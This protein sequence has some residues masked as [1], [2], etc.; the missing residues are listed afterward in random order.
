[1]AELQLPEVFTVN[2]LTRATGASRERLEGLIDSGQFRPIPGT[3]FISAGEALRIGRQLRREPPE[4]SLEP[5]AIF[6]TPGGQSRRSAAPAIVSALMHASLFAVALLLSTLDVKSAVT[7]VRTHEPARLVFVVS[8]GPGGGGGGGGLRN[9]LPAPK[10][11]RKAG[12][13]TPRATVPAVT[14]R[15]AVT[16]TRRD[17]VP[18]KRPTPAAA[19]TVVPKPA[20]REPE[21]LPSN[22]LV[23][24]VVSS[25]SDARNRE[26]VI[27]QGAGNADSQGPGTGGGAG[28]GHGTGNGEGIGSGIGDGSGGGTGGGPYRPGSG[29]EPPRLLH[30]VKA[31]YTDEARRRGL[32]GDVLLE[33]IVRADGSVG[34][35]RMLQRLGA[36]LDERAVQAVRQWR[37]DPARRKGV[38]VDVLVEVAVEFTL[39]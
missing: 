17:S 18:P 9:P 14:L 5:A 33:I 23:A 16:T 12:S 35:V 10:V 34:D 22:V 6:S 13:R 29:I 1:M 21:P 2:E 30:E 32:S 20:P 31:T 37:F 8:P 28:S 19:P 38:P 27:E 36:G 3:R 25:A 15:P 7:E 39:R 4:V 11:E 26:G 24:P